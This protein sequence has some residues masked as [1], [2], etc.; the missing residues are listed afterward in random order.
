M[1]VDSLCAGLFEK[2]AAGGG[3]ALADLPLGR[4]GRPEEC[5]A[6]V[7]FLASERAAFL[8][9]VALA[10]DGGASRALL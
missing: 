3:H 6:L 4:F 1:L 8:T 7:A 10:Y 5:D 2:R 9:G